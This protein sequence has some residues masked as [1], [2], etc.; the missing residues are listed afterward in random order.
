[1]DVDGG[2][3]LVRNSPACGKVDSWIGTR[4]REEVAADLFKIRRSDA[5]GLPFSLKVTARGNRDEK[6]R[7]D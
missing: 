7:A 1:L 6:R 2:M 4:A 3:P 5:V